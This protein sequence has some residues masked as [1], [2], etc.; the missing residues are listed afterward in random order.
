MLSF[1]RVPLLA[2]LGLATLTGC[3]A[4]RRLSDDGGV[5]IDMGGRCL[6]H[7]PAAHRATGATCDHSRPP[8]TSPDPGGG[9][10]SEC[11]TDAD[12]TMDASGR[13]NG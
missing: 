10:P 4:S 6:A 9:P 1:H 7:A 12:C 3:Y 5:G 8:G 11:F 2:L 13:C